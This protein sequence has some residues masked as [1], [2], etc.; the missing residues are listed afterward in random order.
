ML[1]IL[2]AALVAHMLPK[3]SVYTLQGVA[4]ANSTVEW[5]PNYSDLDGLIFFQAIGS[6]RLK[7]DNT[8]VDVSGHTFFHTRGRMPEM[9]CESDELCKVVAHLIT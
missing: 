3:Q 2:A 4:Q 5:S 6:Y 7:Y 8:V 9:Y 1:L